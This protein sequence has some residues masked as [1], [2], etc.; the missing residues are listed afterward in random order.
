MAHADSPADPVAGTPS[1]LTVTVAFSPRANALDEVVL[2]LNVG[3][4]VADALRSSGL[5]ERHGVALEALPSGV[6]G[7]LCSR[8]ALLRHN[9]RV[10]L[11]RPLQVDPMQARRKR[12]SLQ[13][14]TRGVRR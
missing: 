3:S 10:E 9:D 4:T 8:E 1:S 13:R 5:A 11:Y 7:V 2:Q 12:H 14:G 6:W